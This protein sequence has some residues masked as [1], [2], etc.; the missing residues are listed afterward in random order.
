M[1]DTESEQDD[2][3]DSSDNDDRFDR[4]PTPHQEFFEPVATRKERQGRRNRRAQMHK[5]DIQHWTQR[6][7]QASV[8]AGV[9]VRN[10]LVYDRNNK[11]LCYVD[12]ETPVATRDWIEKSLRQRQ[13]DT[14]T[15]TE[16]PTAEDKFQ[17]LCEQA[18]VAI[19]NLLKTKDEWHSDYIEE[20]AK[21]NHA[22]L[23]QVEQSNGDQ[24]H[25]REP[26]FN[27]KPSMVVSPRPQYDLDL[28][29]LKHGQLSWTACHHDH[30]PTHYDAK[31]GVNWFPSKGATCRKL[32][33]DYTN[34]VCEAHLWDKHSK[35]HFPGIDD[36]QQIIQMQL[37][38]NGG[39]YNVFWQHC[40][41]KDCTLH[42][43]SK[44][45]NGFGDEE[46]FLGLRL[47]APG[48][49]PLTPQGPIHSSNSLLN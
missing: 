26:D 25:L 40:L 39:C 9:I 14:G 7:E 35:M 13:R 11:E 4:T 5:E 24:K 32:W 10:G 12:K 44:H 34:D 15:Q 22:T 16:D 8:D 45:N 42:R 33:Y 18:L 31:V 47:R 49:D 1:E 19:N 3:R 43:D 46:P 6:A 36:P 28:R 30:C 29:N 41:N 38:I 37:V 48:I 17:N 23:E 2:A 20:W 27:R 21:D